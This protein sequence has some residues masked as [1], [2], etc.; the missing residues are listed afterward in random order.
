MEAET[1][2]NRIKKILLYISLAPYALLLLMGLACCVQ[3]SFAAGYLAPD[4]LWTPVVYAWDFLIYQLPWGGV[5]GV[6][7]LI[8]FVGYPFY[9]GIDYAA[10]R[11]RPADGGPEK[12]AGKV[13]YTVFLLSF[14]PYFMMAVN[15][16]TGVTFFYTHIYGV[17]AAFV[18]LLI[19][20][21]VPVYPA[22][23]LFEIIYAVRNR[24]RFTRGQKIAA[25]CA[26]AAVLAAIAVPCVVHA[27]LGS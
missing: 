7:L 15:A 6:L 17:D 4:A 19:F 8:I 13:L 18:M 3:K 22:A 9:Y 11:S 2:A 23:L 10:R 27:V 16:A 21:M 14:L 1:K 26:P 12:P 25:W 24:K 5:V 20:C